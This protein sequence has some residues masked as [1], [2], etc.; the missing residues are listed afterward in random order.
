[1]HYAKCRIVW[2]KSHVGFQMGH[3]GKQAVAT[4]GSFQALNTPTRTSPHLAHIFGGSHNGFP[5]FPKNFNN[6]QFCFL[7]FCLFF[8][9]FLPASPASEF[10]RVSGFGPLRYLQPS[11]G[12]ATLDL[13]WFWHDGVQNWTQ[14]G[15]FSES[16][17]TVWCI[18]AAVV[19]PGFYRICIA[20]S[21]TL[22]YFTETYS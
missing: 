3:W 10:R 16:I 12:P 7:P 8:Q 21:N 14:C 5:F 9:K 22:L 11:L 20:T 17:T 6:F 18:I 4:I 15:H 2:A 19:V 1:M 13:S